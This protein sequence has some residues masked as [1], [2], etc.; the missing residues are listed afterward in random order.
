MSREN[1]RG[2]QTRRVRVPDVDYL[3][4]RPIP[5][6]DE[7]IRSF[8]LRAATSN[9]IPLSAI[10]R[11][12]QFSRLESQTVVERLASLARQPVSR[13]VE[14]TLRDCHSRIRAK[15]AWIAD[16]W[17]QY[18]RCAPDGVARREWALA[19]SPVCFHC[20]HL[21]GL[22]DSDLSQMIKVPNRILKVCRDV[23]GAAHR[24]ATDSDALARLEDLRV[25]LPAMASR[26][27]RRLPQH[28]TS[29]SPLV[30]AAIEDLATRREPEDELPRSPAVRALAITMVW[31]EQRAWSSPRAAPHPRPVLIRRENPGISDAEVFTRQMLRTGAKSVVTMRLP[32]SAI[33]FPRTEDLIRMVLGH[34]ELTLDHIPGIY[35][36]VNEPFV[37]EPSEWLWRSRVATVLGQC[38]LLR[39]RWNLADEPIYRL[40]KAGN[41]SQYRG[42]WPKWTPIVHRESDI[43]H[44]MNLARALCLDGLINYRERRDALRSLNA[45]APALAQTLPRA[46]RSFNSYAHLAASW[47]WF[48]TTCDSP[49]T[50]PEA[51][52]LR[53]FDRALNPEGRLTLRSAA[54]EICERD[55]QLVRQLERAHVGGPIAD[56]G[57]GH[58]HVGA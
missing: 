40:T 16:D 22:P 39:H 11:P 3:P 32:R 17:G 56:R 26:L 2:A 5:A 19:L 44:A 37:L 47:M 43:A 31:E 24:S 54:T 1:D 7:S 18:C 25:E 13:I 29:D 12:Q 42:S 21:V 34:T 53:A 28:D 6:A 50:Q 23:S 33:R 14:M 49:R 36:Q 30:S 10:V 48:D 52:L 15:D 46:A 51:E 9:D 58:T 41:Y 35:R 8:V 20:G 38:V 55:S 45:V 57:K 4:A 27:N